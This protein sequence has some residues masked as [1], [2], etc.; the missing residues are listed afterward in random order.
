MAL[1]LSYSLADQDFHHTKSLGVWNVSTQLLR[2]LAAHPDL[3]RLTVFT[4]HRQTDLQLPPNAVL[5][6]HDSAI[7]GPFGRVQW[8]QWGLYSAA[9]K[10]GNPWLFLPKGFASIYRHCPVRLAAYVHDAMHDHYR[11]TYSPNP[12]A[13]EDGYFTRS[14][15]ATLRNAEIIFTN[16]EFTRTEILRLARQWDL[17]V[18]RLV[19]AGVG[20]EMPSALAD[21]PRQRIVVLA[22]IWPHK[23]TP[24]AVEYLTRWA[25]ARPNAMGVDWIGPLPSGLKL[26]A[27]PGWK[28]YNRL[29][30]DNYQRAMRQ[31]AVVV[32]FSTYEGFG[33]PPVE[34]TLAG[35]A[36]VYSAIPAMS[37]TMGECGFRF[38]NDSFEQFAKAMDAAM[39]A[40]PD[41][42]AAWRSQLTARHQWPSVARRIVEELA[43]LEVK[44]PSRA[45]AAR[46]A[47]SP[48]K[49]LI[50]AHTPPPLHGQSYMVQLMLDGFGGDRRRHQA[51]A[52]SPHGIA[53]FHVNARLSRDLEDVGEAR[54]GKLLV[55]FGYCLTAVGCRFRYGVNTLYYVPAPGK[56]AA[57][58][59][60]WMVMGFCRPFYRHIIL[61]WHA[62]G[63]PTWLTSQPNRLTRRLTHLLLGHP[64][65][66]I[67]ISQ[68]NRADA[69]L[70]Q[71]RRSVIVP[72]GIPDPCPNFESSLLPY[73][74]A[75]L[76]ARRK[77]LT[78]EPLSDLERARC[79]GDPEVVRIL[80]LAHCSREKGLFDA[81]EGVR[82]AHRHLR[83][84]QSPFRLKLVVCG[85][86]LKPEDKTDFDR[87]LADGELQSLIEY[88]GF[89]GG[90]Q[91]D[92]AFRKAD[93][94]CFPTFYYAESF[95]LVVT[96]AMAYGLPVI[97]TRWRSVPEVLPPDYPGLV[98]PNQ[99]DQIATALLRSLGEYDP[100]IVRKHFLDHFTSERHL[101]A[102]AAAIR[103]D[104]TAHGESIQK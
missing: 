54:L 98:D 52:V 63:L 82:L 74:L 58:L 94:F 20:F 97:A 39:T 71:P 61:H 92:Q 77:L 41:Q 47:P 35:A 93:M 3:G 15:Q 44:Q 23:C 51:T 90:A 81:I 99:P 38:A 4:N 73:R 68:F 87:C 24:L 91:K 80:F 25:D 78:G 46:R 66:S 103:E 100:R 28:H 85:N 67:S 102:L 56:Q 69:D 95:G 49:V 2:H 70:L 30:Q 34:G 37:E 26:P 27:R 60:D 43:A 88:A 57:L 7:T 64:D 104:A 6:R 1:N 79:D 5:E 22:G 33:M 9:K 11:Q 8:D 96:E 55:L 65:L 36:A 32:Y 101:A 53:C 18:P 48:K 72:N 16:S 19:H 84:Q 62:A 89:V 75:R 29:S 31:A 50:F 21:Q 59:R 12:L 45:V 13:N 40:T 42:L 83:A 10:S 86:F 14:L 76:G 17:P